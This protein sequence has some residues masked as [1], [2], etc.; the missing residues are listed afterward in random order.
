MK[1]KL[2]IILSVL[3]ILAL[4]AALTACSGGSATLE[5]LYHDYGFGGL[6]FTLKEACV[7]EEPPVTY[8]DSTYDEEN[9]VY[10]H[11][12]TNAQKYL[13]YLGTE[14]FDNTKSFFA[15]SMKIDDCTFKEF[16]QTF[17]FNIFSGPEEDDV[18]DV[19][20]LYSAP[21]GYQLSADKIHFTES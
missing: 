14:G 4:C 19:Y 10:L 8:D 17:S 7:A 21:A 18:T 13:S 6:T 9:Y 5:P 12:E 15:E 1:Q 3:L 2:T 16:N 20:I 11:F